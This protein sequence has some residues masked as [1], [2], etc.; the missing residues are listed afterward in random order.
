MIRNAWYVV[1]WPDE[2]GLNEPVERTVV[3]KPM[4]MWRTASGK[5]VAL[6][7]R[8]LHKRFPLS[9][10]AIRDGVLQCAYHGFCYNEAG[11]CVEIP[12]LTPGEPIPAR[13]NLRTFPVVEKESLV[14]VWPGDPAAMTVDPPSTP[15]LAS[16]DYDVFIGGTLE[17]AANSQLLIENLADLT[18]FFPLHSST[19]GNVENNRIPVHVRTEDGRLV[20]GR[21]VDHYVL[22]PSYVEWFHMEVADREHIITVE[23]P[24]LVTV[25]I[26]LAPPGML[27]TDRETGMMLF[28]AICPVS[29]NQFAWRWACTSHREHRV[30]AD[31]TVAKA[32]GTA[33]VSIA[34]EDRWA[35]EQQQR[36]FEYEDDGYAEVG[37]K[38]DAPVFA[39]RRMLQQLGDSEARA[40][41]GPI[42][43]GSSR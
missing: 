37:I 38:G 11:I 10:G 35:I 27:G 41:V 24:S 33:T 26:R 20:I 7:N 6:D 8:C 39:V 12:A 34:E 40:V 9:E 23:N 43:A 13:A 31:I 15:R 16:P 2:F 3:G 19:I 1:G 30:N 18:H 36:M 14:W 17:T 32:V 29:E 21:L 5:V 25:Q 42:E 22:P 28:H 4:V